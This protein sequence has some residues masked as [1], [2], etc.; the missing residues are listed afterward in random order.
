MDHNIFISLYHSGYEDEKNSGVV[1]AFG[2]RGSSCVSDCK[3][4]TGY[5]DLGWRNCNRDFFLMLSKWTREGLGYGDSWMIL[6][7][8]ISLG[9]WDILLLLSIAL[10]CSGILAGILLIKG[11]WSKKVSFPFIPFLMVGYVGVLYL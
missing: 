2:K 5:C 4:G 9:L 1:Y 8:G 3:L 6:I 7:L 11:K 10:T